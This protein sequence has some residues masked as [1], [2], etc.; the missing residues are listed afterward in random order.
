[1]LAE[2]PQQ[3]A[4]LIRDVLRDTPGPAR[5]I[6]ILN[7]AAALWTVGESPD[8]RVCVAIVSEVL[9]SGAA[10]DTLQRLAKV[11]HE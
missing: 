6:V 9:R 4:E 10:A 5:D 2:S 1:M 8:L 7:A 11:S 3:S